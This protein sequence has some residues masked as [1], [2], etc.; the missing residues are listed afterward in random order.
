MKGRLITVGRRKE[1]VARVYLVPGTGRVWV[2]G[3]DYR[4]YFHRPLLELVIDKPLNV[5]GLKEK[6]DVIARVRG[7]GKSGQAD[8]IRLGIARWIVANSPELRPVLKKEGLL[9]RDPRAK[10]RKKYGLHRARR[11]RQYRKR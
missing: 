11:A 3:Y 10:E 8:A 4:K 7:G 6:Y 2:N 9:T 5:T 1:A